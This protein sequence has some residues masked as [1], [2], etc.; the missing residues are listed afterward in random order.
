M[1]HVSITGAQVEVTA[2]AQ[3][4]EGGVRVLFSSISNNSVISFISINPISA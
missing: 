4:D 2:P 3:K 1:F